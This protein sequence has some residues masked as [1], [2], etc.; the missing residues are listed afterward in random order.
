[1]QQT[2]RTRTNN[3]NK[4]KQTWMISVDGLVSLSGWREWSTMLIFTRV[5]LWLNDAF[6]RALEPGG[7]S[8]HD[9]GFRSIPSAPQR[10]SSPALICDIVNR[11]AVVVKGRKGGSATVR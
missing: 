7:I 9:E 8:S 10:R 6:S 3:R 5:R 2:R 11:R 4:R 1:M